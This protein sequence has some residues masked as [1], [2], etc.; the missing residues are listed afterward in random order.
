MLP[1]NEASTVGLPPL[2]GNAEDRA[3]AIGTASVGRPVQRV[4]AE[5]QTG[6]Q[7]H[8]PLLPLNVAS[9]VGLPPL[10]GTLKTV[11]YLPLQRQ[12][13]AVSVVP[14]RVLPLSVKPAYGIFAVAAVERGQHRGAAAAQRER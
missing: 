7:G 9:T 14:Y 3:V 5:R 6:L 13:T 10:T 2:T 1:L 8:S 12:V 4:A 11:P